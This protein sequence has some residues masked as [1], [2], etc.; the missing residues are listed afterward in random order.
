MNET[1]E[2]INI[3]VA[4]PEDANRLLEIYSPYVKNT[5]VTFEYS[6]PSLEEFKSRIAS[7]LKKYPYLVAEMNGIIVGYAYAGP[8]RPREAY[9]HSAETS[10]YVSEDVHKRGIGRALYE[11]L[12]ELL[13]KQNVYLLY[14][15]TAYTE[16]DDEFLPKNSPVFHEHLGYKKVGVFENCGYKF[17]K[18][19]SVAWFEKCIAERPKHPDPFIPFADT[20]KE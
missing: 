6:V 20:A 5:A 13:I 2:N 8:I 4:T 16:Y 15:G 3:R 18:W 19:Y 14:A 10:I 1:R 11:R 12:E 9:K 7:T 17:D